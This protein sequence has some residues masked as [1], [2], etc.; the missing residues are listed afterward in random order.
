MTALKV[1]SPKLNVFRYFDLILGFSVAILI[2]SNIVA[3]KLISFGPIITDGGAI[4]FPLSYILG[5][6]LT[7]VYGY[8]Y[9]RRAIWASFGFMILAVIVFKLV[10]LMPSAA[11][12]T[13]QSSYQAILGFVPRIVLASLCAYILGQFMNSFVLAKLK[14]LSGG[15]SLW[16]RLVSSTAIGELVDTTV[17]ALI[18]F[19]GLL[20]GFVMIKYILI[21]WIFK[22][23]VEI[24]MLP[25]SYKV[26]GFL[27]KSEHVDK[28]DYDT[29]FSPFHIK[30]G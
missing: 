30:V 23:V 26:I 16:F 6:I 5:D 8:S 7:E 9:A 2:I 27:K 14:I 21:G 19:S 17:F 11:E 18:A 3:V 4:I 1:T 25:I 13:N 15:K 12:W 29:N 22:V 28:Y 10:E 20:H 24:V